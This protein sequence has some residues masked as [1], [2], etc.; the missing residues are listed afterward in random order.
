MKNTSLKLDAQIISSTV[1]AL[2]SKIEELETEVEI[3]TARNAEY[4]EIIKQ[5]IL[6]IP[7][8]PEEVKKSV[9]DTCTSL[10]EDTRNFIKLLH[11]IYGNET[12]YVKDRK[13]MQLRSENNKSNINYSLG[14]LARKKKNPLVQL[15]W[16]DNQTK[17]ESFQLLPP[18]E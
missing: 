5:P 1:E 6:L 16:N 18:V 13:F 9:W 2:I 4:E 14:A 7:D 10:G 8:K 15:N 17:V 3:L 12:V 11:K